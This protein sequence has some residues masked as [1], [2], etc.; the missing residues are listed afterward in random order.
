MSVPETVCVGLQEEDQDSG[1]YPNSLA[2]MSSEQPGGRPDT[3]ALVKEEEKEWL[4]D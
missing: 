2:D 3:H 4:K 1:I